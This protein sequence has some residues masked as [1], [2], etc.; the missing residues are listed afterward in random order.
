[1]SA[2]PGHFHLGPSLQAWLGCLG[3][4]HK[5]HLET[6]LASWLYCKYFGHQRQEEG[7]GLNGQVLKPLRLLTF[8]L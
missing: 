4:A 8:S 5:V 2:F 3:P 6:M 7:L 1:M